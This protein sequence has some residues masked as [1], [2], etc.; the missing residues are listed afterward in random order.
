MPQLFFKSWDRDPSRL[1]KIKR[2]YL[3]IYDDL[4]Q[5][6]L[7]ESERTNVRFP[8]IAA[9]QNSFPF[10]IDKGYLQEVR[11]ML[12]ASGEINHKFM[13][14]LRPNGVKIYQEDEEDQFGPVVD[15]PAE[16]AEF[17]PIIRSAY[18][19]REHEPKPE[20]RDGK[21][22]KINYPHRE[23]ARHKVHVDGSTRVS[24]LSESDLSVADH[25]CVD[26]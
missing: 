11:R 17:D 7:E 19:F 13:G 6:H 1:E 21:K 16:V 24:I 10:Y 8:S 25:F 15:D 9:I 26:E 20:P 2:I 22:R 18:L 4:T 14:N 3:D 23:Y 5:A 12:I